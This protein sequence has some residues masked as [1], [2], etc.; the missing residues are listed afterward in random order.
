M[1]TTNNPVPLDLFL[2][3]MQFERIAEDLYAQLAQVSQKLEVRKLFATLSSEEKKHRDL[4]SGLRRSASSRTA[5]PQYEQEARQLMRAN[6]LPSPADVSAVALRGDVTGA[7]KM[8][9]KMEQNSVG[10]YGGLMSLNP[11]FTGDLARIMQEEQQHAMLISDMLSTP[12]GSLSK[13]S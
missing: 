7:L 9:L 5:T 3:A 8:A 6:I 12:Q 11:E 13:R 2:L 10:F 4:F 1:T